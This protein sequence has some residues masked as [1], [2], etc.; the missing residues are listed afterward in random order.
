MRAA[1]RRKNTL[2][3]TVSTVVV[4]AALL[5]LVVSSPGW[6]RVQQTFFNVH[7]GIEVLPAIAKGLL[8]NITLTIIGTIAIS[9]IGLTW[10]C[11]GRRPRRPWRRS[12]CWPRCMSTSSAGCRRCW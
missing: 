6:E 1:A 9:I 8:L 10:R 7:Y 5:L 11:C 12:G 4:L 2:I 3:A